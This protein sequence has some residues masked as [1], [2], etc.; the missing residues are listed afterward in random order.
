ML[1]TSTAFGFAL[2]AATVLALAAGHNTVLIDDFNDGDSEGWEE[3]DFTGG[4]G[5]FDASSVLL[6]GNLWLGWILLEGRRSENSAAILER[7]DGNAER[8]T[9]FA[10]YP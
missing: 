9:R 4:L 2:L 5:V 3:T 10:R 6:M 8:L 1:R 7:L